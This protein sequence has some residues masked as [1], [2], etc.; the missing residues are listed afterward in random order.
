MGT[1]VAVLL[2]CLACVEALPRPGEVVSARVGSASA[3]SPANSETDA[4]GPRVHPLAMLKPAIGA[5][6]LNE[7]LTTLTASPDSIYGRFALG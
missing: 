5:R 4:R 2:L 6:P 3:H 7:T 1:K